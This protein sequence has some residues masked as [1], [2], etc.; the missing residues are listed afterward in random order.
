MWE[1]VLTSFIQA[2][3]HWMTVEITYIAFWF[4]IFNFYTTFFL[5]LFFSV[6]FYYFVLLADLCAAVTTGLI[7]S[8]RL[9]DFQAILFTTRPLKHQLKK[10]NFKG[11]KR[12][13]HKFEEV[14]VFFVCFSSFAN[15]PSAPLLPS[16]KPFSCS[17]S[18]DAQSWNALGN[19]KLLV[20]T[21]SHQHGPRGRGPSVPSG[22]PAAV[23]KGPG[24]PSS[25]TALSHNYF[26]TP[27]GSTSDLWERLWLMNHF[28]ESFMRIIS[29][30]C[31]DGLYGP[32]V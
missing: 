7:Q 10:M 8:A 28:R 27:G 29:K 6:L 32:S 24:G 1:S 26:T 31:I 16:A 18:F 17:A 11:E 9:Y 13:F 21:G 20:L 30:Q 19:T 2:K 3:V 4:L 23:N 25:H 22:I 15:L 12:T 14:A 5:I